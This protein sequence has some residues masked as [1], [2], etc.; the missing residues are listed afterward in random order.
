LYVNPRPD[1]DEII[2]GAEQGL[3]KG[4]VAFDATGRFDP[5]KCWFYK[6]VLADLYPD[7]CAA[8]SWLDIGCG[9][10]ELL[11][12]VNEV[13]K[14][15]VAIKGTEPN[16]QKQKSAQQKGLDVTYF[17]IFTHNGKYDIASLLNVYSHLPDPSGFISR[18]KEILTPHGELVIETG[19]S[20]HFSPEE[21]YR[22][23]FLPDHLS[24]ASEQILRD[25]L[26]RNGFEVVVV[27]H[28]PIVIPHV[29]AVAREFLK[30]VWPGQKSRIKY[31]FNVKYRTDM[32]IRA[33]AN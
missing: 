27:K 14:G 23:L 11:A 18:C 7:G 8:K 6:R 3:H 17:D 30:I 1:A 32:F 26:T 25:I 28:Y 4:D 13:F 5:L 16:I 2:E 29:A 33:K 19:D 22:P 20:A 9:H 31:M 24:F 12:T 15:S 10:G 21:H